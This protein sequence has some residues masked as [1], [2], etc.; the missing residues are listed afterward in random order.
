MVKYDKYYLQGECKFNCFKLV[1]ILQYKKNVIKKYLFNF[2]F[3]N[4]GIM[5][6]DDTVIRLITSVWLIFMDE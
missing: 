1:E 4:V 5:P 2:T 3:I 6:F